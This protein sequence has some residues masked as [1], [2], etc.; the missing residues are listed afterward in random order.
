[1]YL[2]PVFICFFLRIGIWLRALL[3]F[4]MKKK[5]DIF[6]IIFDLAVANIAF[7]LGTN[8]RF[9]GY[10]NLPSHAYPTVF[11]VLSLAVFISFIA[12]GE[13][14]EHEKAIKKSFQGLMFSFFILSSLTYYFNSYAFSRGILLITIGTSVIISIISRGLLSFNRR[15]KGNSADKN[16]AILGLSNYTGRII[17]S[18]QN[19]ESRTANL[20]GIISTKKESISQFNNIPIVGNIEYLKQIIK[21]I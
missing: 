5:E 11:I 16:I 19:S 15:I 20:I 12:V 2:I 21:A 10:F 14:F 17:D 9:G 13:Y 6:F 7:I 1:M 8:Y 4:V 3:S 18:F